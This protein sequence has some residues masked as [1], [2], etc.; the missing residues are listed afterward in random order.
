MPDLSL[1][2]WPRGLRCELAAGYLGISPSLFRQL[3]DAGKL[4]RPVAISPGRQVWLREDLDASLDRLAG[5]APG[6][7]EPN[8]WDDV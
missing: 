5:R 1:P 3:V 2:H 4:P 8:S 6:V 7:A